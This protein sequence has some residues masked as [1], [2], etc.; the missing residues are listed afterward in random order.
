MLERIVVRMIL[1]IVVRMGVMMVM[2]MVV[3]MEPIPYKPIQI[4]F[5]FILIFDKIVWVQ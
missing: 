2:I 1:R 3:M 4:I 5:F